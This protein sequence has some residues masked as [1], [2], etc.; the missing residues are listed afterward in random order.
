MLGAALLVLLGLLPWT[1][2]LH[3]VGRGVDVYLFLAGM[4]LLSE[5]ARREGLF[6]WV[7]AH[8]VRR[9]RGSAS[10]CSC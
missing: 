6:D 3:A 1:A 9:A 10:R 7:A 5:I 4:M 2:A 8:A